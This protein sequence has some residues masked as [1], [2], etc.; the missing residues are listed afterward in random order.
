MTNK[1][2][3]VLGVL[4]HKL[5]TKRVA[6]QPYVFDKS[7]MPPGRGSQ[8]PRVVAPLKSLFFVVKDDALLKHARKGSSR[9]LLEESRVST[10]W[11]GSWLGPSGGG[12]AGRTE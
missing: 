5:R 7:A 1:Q 9:R 6:E 2:H 11:R 4:Q 10:K 12:Y 8:R 3:C